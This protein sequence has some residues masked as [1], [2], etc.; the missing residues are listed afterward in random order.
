MTARSRLQFGYNP[1]TGDRLLEQVNPST[2][3]KDLQGVL[4]VASQ[5]FSS[6][7]ISDHHMT[8]DRFR[9][10][11]WSVLMWV[12][13][14]YPGPLLGTCVMGN[15]YRHPPFLAKMV[16]S[17]Q[18]LSSGRFIFGYGAGWSEEEY[19]AYGYEY[20]SAR[21]RI[22]QLDEAVRVIKAL[23]TQVPATY[24]G[25][26]YSVKDAYCEPRPD[27]IPPLMLAGDGEKYM[28]RVV[29]EHADWWLSY[30][31]RPEVQARK[32]AVLAE[33]CRSFG[34]DPSEIKKAAP[35]TVFLDK[36]RAAARNRAGQRLE[37]ENPAFAGDAAE[38]RDH[39]EQIQALG[40]DMVQLS[41][42]GFPET[43][44]LKLFADKVLPHFG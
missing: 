9:L 17:L 22:A 38:F 35:L 36:D 15:S 6:L 23:W 25:T 8:G 12:A 24:E 3:T 2:F 34:R 20:P 29:A 28:L 1:P 19:H 14:R 5:S 10:E 41:F 43:D 44:D 31:R 30:A 39:L 27:P 37:G 33:H 42:A 32:L 7:W 18:Y 26:Y 16:A 21:V 40:F 11:C 4:D 13:A